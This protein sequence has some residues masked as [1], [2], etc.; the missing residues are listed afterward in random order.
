M[1]Q[2]ILLLFILFLLFPACKRDV[3]KNAEI[4]YQKAEQEFHEANFDKARADLDEIKHRYPNA[5]ETRKKAIIL[6]QN[7]ELKDAQIKLAVVDSALYAINLTYKYIRSKAE[8]DKNKGAATRE[9]LTEVIT[10][11]IKRDSLQVKFDLLCGQIRYI[12]KKQ[13][14][15]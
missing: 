6:R 15:N 3:D 9:E 7:I 10:T 5:I 1:K 13:K 12:H 4:L 14:E 11:R 8:T 2:N